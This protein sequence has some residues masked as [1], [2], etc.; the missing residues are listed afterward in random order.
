MADS[1]I[2]AWGAML[3]VLTVLIVFFVLT[4][5]SKLGKIKT[6]LKLIL[7]VVF[8]G[9]VAGAGY[10]FLLLPPHN[11]VKLFGVNSPV[12]E[13]PST[14]SGPVTQIFI[15][16]LKN[17]YKTPI[18][19]LIT[20]S[21]LFFI[22]F[23]AFKI[24]RP[25]RRQIEKDLKDAKMAA[26]N[27]LEDLQAEKI[28]LAEAKAKDDA[29][30][31]SI[32]EGVVAT[33]QAG[34]M[35]IMNKAAEDLLGFTSLEIMGKSFVEAVSLEDVEG[36]QIPNTQ[37][38]ITMALTL[39]KAT[40]AT[41]YFV[42]KDGTKFP[43]S[44]TATPVLLDAK[45][46]GAIIVFHDI[47]KEKEIDKAKTEF[48]SLAS[49]QLR[50]PLT[51]IE[52]TTELFAK[53][54]KL[55][56]EGKRYLSDIRFSAKR[57]GTLVKLLLNVSRIES[58]KLAVSPEPLELVEFINEYVHERQM[59]Y[60]KKKVSLIFETHPAELRITTDK[61]LLGYILRNLVSNA[62]DYTPPQGSV[63]ISVKKKK[64]TVLITVQ[65][66]GI[67]IPKKE[68]GRIFQKFVRASN[69]VITKPDGTGLGLYIAAEAVKLLGG[70]IWFESEEGHGSTFFVEVP[71]VSHARPGERGLVLESQLAHPKE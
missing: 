22:I 67:G 44:I 32:G 21:F 34:K 35:I 14:G 33:D 38:P 49:H 43:V 1:K 13:F 29:L 4:R 41:Y 42:R 55:T 64:D 69:A 39:S 57:L 11:Q 19:G 17:L 8:L 61:N 12:P 70:K 68:S 28:R 3:A 26:R 10:Y 2:S 27:V 62:I 47:T 66:T 54:E 16:F 5:K 56:E 65:D 58:G 48:V 51:G 45:P 25:D 59:F 18:Y 30:L 63:E 15:Q 60:G 23:M 71:F 9:G 40:T 24:I 7:I 37:Q 6:K 53:K 50:T 52:W 20:S 31:E 36:K 46:T